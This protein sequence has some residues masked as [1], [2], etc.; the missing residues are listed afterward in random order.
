MADKI[1]MVDFLALHE[2]LILEST[3]MKYDELTM[4]LGY[5]PLDVK[6]LLGQTQKEVAELSTRI[7]EGLK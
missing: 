1:T 6:P 5:V 2:L 3:L 7:W 4:H